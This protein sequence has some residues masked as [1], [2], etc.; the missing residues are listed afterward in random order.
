MTCCV[1]VERMIK[2]TITAVTATVACAAAMFASGAGTAMAPEAG[3][4]N[5]NSPLAASTNAW[6]YGTYI[7]SKQPTYGFYTSNVW[8]FGYAYQQYVGYPCSRYAQPAG[9]TLGGYIQVSGAYSR[10]AE[11]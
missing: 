8:K 11:F 3:R 5:S 7:E 9:T 6:A 10:C 1:I 4:L 2:H